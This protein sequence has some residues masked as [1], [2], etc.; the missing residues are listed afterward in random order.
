MCTGLE[1]PAAIAIGSS[2]AGA[3]ASV[4]GG[5]A[6][7]D[8]QRK[9]GKARQAA[10]DR[11]A[12]VAE[13]AAIDAIARGEQEVG[14]VRREASDVISAQ[15]VAYAGAGVDISSG[16]VAD[17]IA[18]TRA[19]A[20]LDALKVKQNAA[21]AAWGFKQ[22]AE[23][24]RRGGVYERQA[25]DNEATGTLLTGVAGGV[26]GVGRAFSTYNSNRKPSTVP[27]VSK[28]KP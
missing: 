8:A 22:E 25:A 10:A 6:G 16:T 23:N 15:R 2:L 5:I 26:E 18:S 20:E 19:K 12:G 11:Q 14:Q 17:V 28:G 24:L 13:D 21:R 27:V 1:I 3:G 7:S 9:A 4:Y